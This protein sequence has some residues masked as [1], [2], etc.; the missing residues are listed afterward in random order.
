LPRVRGGS[1]TLAVRAIT[2]H[3]WYPTEDLVGLVFSS[4]DV[5]DERTQAILS[6]FQKPVRKETVKVW[7][8][9]RSGKIENMELDDLIG[10]HGPTC[11][12][13]YVYVC[14]YNICMIA[15]I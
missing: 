15:R 8:Q 1:Y 11:M 6:V 9:K 5:P 3:L 2:N 7:K 13:I 4:D 14:M 10:M 12:C